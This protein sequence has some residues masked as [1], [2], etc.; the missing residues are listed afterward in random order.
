MSDAAFL[1]I[2]LRPHGEHAPLRRAARQQGGRV[3]TLSPWKITP[4]DDATARTALAEALA[5]PQVIFTSP[6]A[7]KAAAALAAFTPPPVAQFLA[8]GEG[9]R[10]AL[11]RA[12]IAQAIAP[13][14]MD[15][16][17]LL[18][19]P[20][21]AGQAAGARIGLITAPGGRGEIIR[22][23][24]ARGILVQRADVYQRT[25]LP[26]SKRSLA[27]LA[28]A[29]RNNT[30][31]Y[32][33]LSSGEALTRI[34]ALLPDTLGAAMRAQA[35]IIAAS[36]RLAELAIGQGFHLHAIARSARPGDL[37][38]ALAPPEYQ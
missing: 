31:L 22:Q 7:V 24:Q 13:E 33:A 4:L 30:P 9:T 21:L 11:V 5:C 32:L 3:L 37:L 14:R 1:L 29:L 19:L 10:R 26:L 35:A 36:P 25:P 8:V 2:S 6:A 38:A 18:A 27:Q 23:L 17:G 20:M 34:S 28:E 15:S 12:G 16:E